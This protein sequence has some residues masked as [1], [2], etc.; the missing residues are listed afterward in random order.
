[1]QW[2][3]CLHKLHPMNSKESL[4]LSSRTYTLTFNSERMKA[5][6]YMYV[7]VYMLWLMRNVDSTLYLALVW[8]LFHWKITK[9]VCIWVCSWYFYAHN[10]LA[11]LWV[12]MLISC[13]KRLNSLYLIK[14][15]NHWDLS[16]RGWEMCILV[17]HT[18]ALLYPNDPHTLIPVQVY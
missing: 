5:M 12:Q 6:T 16:T 8:S 7:Y 11:V 13:A 15:L 1:M 3:L 18:N 4:L 2:L 10:A 14:E 17:E 9:D